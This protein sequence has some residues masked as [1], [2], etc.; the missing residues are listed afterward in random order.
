MGRNKRP[1]EESSTPEAPENELTNWLSDAESGEGSSSADEPDTTWFPSGGDEAKNDALD[2]AVAALGGEHDDM[3]GEPVTFVDEHVSAEPEAPAPVT[4]SVAAPPEPPTEPES[5][6]ASEPAQDMS[7]FLMESALDDLVTAVD[8][9]MQE[10]PPAMGV[11]GFETATQDPYAAGRLSRVVTS[12]GIGIGLALVLLV[13]GLVP[14]SQI[15][16]TTVQEPAVE[17]AA[18]LRDLDVEPEAQAVEVREDM[19]GRSRKVTVDEDLLPDAAPL[20]DLTAAREVSLS[21]LQPAPKAT[22]GGSGARAPAAPQELTVHRASD[23]E[24]FNEAQVRRASGR[25]QLVSEKVDEALIAA[26]KSRLEIRSNQSVV[27]YINGAALGK[28]GYKDHL[29]A[30]GTY[31]IR[32]MLPGNPDSAQEV[33]VTVDQVGQSVPVRFSF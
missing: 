30:P 8:T 3:Y 1:T 11:A 10:P 28:I 26:Q 25:T 29:V 27:A 5:A 13:V 17:N 23:A 9:D 2:E 21:D 32:A 22:G 7:S 18:T 33:T 31:T 12:L 15:L 24:F 20:P 4:E 6:P 19:R 14:W 16:S